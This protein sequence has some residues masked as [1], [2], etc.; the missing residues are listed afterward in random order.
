MWYLYTV[1]SSMLMA[2]LMFQSLQGHDGLTMDKQHMHMSIFREYDIRGIVGSEIPIPAVYDFGRAI[3]TYIAQ[4]DPA[5]R[6][7]AVGMD[8]RTHSPAIQEQLCSAL[9]DSGFDV[10]FIGTCP[11]PALYFSLHMLPV[12]AGVMITASHNPKDYNGFKLCL[13]TDSIAGAAIQELKKLY[14]AGTR[15]PVQKTGTVR[16]NPIHKAYIAWLVEHFAHLKGLHVP[17]ILDCGNGAAGTIVPDLIAALGW[18]GCTILYADVD[19]TYPNHDA[20]PT[21]ASN[22]ATVKKMLAQ[23]DYWFGAGFDGDADRMDAMTSNGQLLSGDQLLVLFMQQILRKIPGAA[24]IC[25]VSSSNTLVSML[26]AW[27]ARPCMVPTG[28]TNIKIAMKREKAALGG[29][30]SCH[31]TFAD[32]YFGFD[33]G[34][35]ALLRLVELVYTAQAPLASLCSIFPTLYNSPVIRIPMPSEHIPPMLAAIEKHFRLDTTAS[36]LTIDGIRITT[37]FGWALIRPS[38]T[39]PVLCL[40]FEAS[41]PEGLADLKNRFKAILQDHIDQKVL[42]AYM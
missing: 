36:L 30:L 28:H 29:E 15:I 17:I 27:G 41:S 22:M 7:I 9:A 39:Q 3:A 6:A 37:P 40:R 33:D 24:A 34:I 12:Q 5:V 26:A 10:F 4:R 18:T 11:T 32:R 19:G 13:G 14:Q 2:V 38:N 16:N 8:G 31:F 21:V 25:D 42:N 1:A 20:D 35:Y 23:G